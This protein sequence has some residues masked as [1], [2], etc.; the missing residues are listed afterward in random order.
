[1]VVYLHT[2]SQC[3]TLDVK[4]HGF[5]GLISKILSTMLYL[6]MEILKLPEQA[7]IKH[8]IKATPSKGCALGSVVWHGLLCPKGLIKCDYCHGIMRQ[9]TWQSKWDNIN[10]YAG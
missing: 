10:K 2:K 7:S 8:G 4:Q 5:S 9:Y 3:F 1:M 6:I